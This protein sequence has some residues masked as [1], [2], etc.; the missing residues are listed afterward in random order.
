MGLLNPN[1]YSA[2]VFL[3]PALREVKQS[4]YIMKKLGKIIGYFLP[5]IKL[6]QQ[7]TDDTKYQFKDTHRTFPNHYTGR[8]IPGTYRVVL[9][10][11]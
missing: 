9:N 1:K 5:K 3:T 2:I 7:G 6:T 10:A 4:Q 8:N 11:I